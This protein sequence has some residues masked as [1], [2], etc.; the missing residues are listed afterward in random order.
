MYIALVFSFQIR[1]IEISP[2]NSRKHL[3]PSGL[4]VVTCDLIRL[5]DVETFDAIYILKSHM[6]NPE[7]CCNILICMRKVT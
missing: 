3:V 6:R 4:C 7:P 1:I 2:I 5:H